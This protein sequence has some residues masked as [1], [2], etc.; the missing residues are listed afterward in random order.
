M[1]KAA[2][3]ATGIKAHYGAQVTT[4]L[5]HNAKEQERIRAELIAL[6]EQLQALQ[7]DRTLLLGVQ[8]ALGGEDSPLSTPQKAGS[9]AEAKA[10]DL[11]KPRASRTLPKADGRKQAAAKKADKTSSPEGENAKATVAAAAP[12]LVALAREHL[13]ELSEPRSAAEIAAALAQAHPGRDIK[14]T[15]V[16][17]TLEGLVAKG[18]AHRAKQGASVFYSASGEQ[19]SQPTQETALSAP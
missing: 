15:V 18:Q 1:S 11:P 12:T 2:Q 17:T 3:E 6:E 7:Y 19:S 10:A 5:E 16:R 13:G 14:P 8:Q 9:T 4:D